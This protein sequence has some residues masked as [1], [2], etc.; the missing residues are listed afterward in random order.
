[1]PERAEIWGLNKMNGGQMGFLLTPRWSKRNER[2]VH[3]RTKKSI[4]I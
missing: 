2:I 4:Q 3:I 1:M